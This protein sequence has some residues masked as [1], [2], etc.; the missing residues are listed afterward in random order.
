MGADN[1]L[2]VKVGESDT[3][4]A[5]KAKEAMLNSGFGHVSKSPNPRRE[6]FGPMSD[7]DTIIM[8]EDLPEGWEITDVHRFD[9]AVYVGV[10]PKE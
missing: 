1:H 7:D 10:G 8:N 9:D 3:N 6:L 4:D 2:T 5:E